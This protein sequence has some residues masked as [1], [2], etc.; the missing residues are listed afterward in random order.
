M[1]KLTRSQLKKLI[2]K[3]IHMMKPDYRPHARRPG[4]RGA[5]VAGRRERRMPTI[6]KLAASMGM[7]AATL[8]DMLEDELLGGSDGMAPPG[9]D[10]SDLEAYT[11]GSGQDPDDLGTL[12]E[13]AYNRIV[14]RRRLRDLNEGLT[15]G[16]IKKLFDYMA[17]KGMKYSA[18]GGAAVISSIGDELIDMI[19]NDDLEG[20]AERFMDAYNAL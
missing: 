17:Q 14:E 8:A 16:G 7:D 12:A 18:W 10:T 13:A 11:M 3:E 15:P 4:Y 2:M 20:A 5:T 1:K 6:E 19:V 9:T